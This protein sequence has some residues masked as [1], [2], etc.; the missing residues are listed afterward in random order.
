VEN[1][2]KLLSHVKKSPSIVMDK[3]LGRNEENGGIYPMM[4]P[5]YVLNR[6][7]DSY[8]KAFTST[9]SSSLK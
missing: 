5:E 7:Y 9:A 6:N 1:S 8:V 4:N 3:T 2:Y